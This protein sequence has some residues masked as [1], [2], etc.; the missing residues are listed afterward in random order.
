VVVAVVVVVG[1][2]HPGTGLGHG[3]KAPCEKYA[4]PSPLLVACKTTSRFRVVAPAIQI[5]SSNGV[6]ACWLP[7]WM[8][9]PSGVLMQ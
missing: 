9:M 1:S 6:M 4:T 7:K 8:S 2:K 3:E 5:D